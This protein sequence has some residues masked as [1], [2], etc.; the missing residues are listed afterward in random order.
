MLKFTVNL[1]TPISI[2]FLTLT[3]YQDILQSFTTNVPFHDNLKHAYW[4]SALV[5][6]QILTHSPFIRDI[7]ITYSAS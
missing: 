5:V 1:L 3:T 6:L 2:C 4:G 7:S